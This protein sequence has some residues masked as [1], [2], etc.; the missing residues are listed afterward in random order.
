MMSMPS[1]PAGGV[2]LASHSN[3]SVGLSFQLRSA[4]SWAPA[5]PV[6]RT[7]CALAASRAR[8][9]SSAP[10]SGVTSTPNLVLIAW[11]AACARA[12]VREDRPTC[13]PSRLNM[14]AARIPTG[15][16]PASTTAFLPASGAE[17]ARQA[18][19]AAAVVFDPLLS[20]ITDTRK[21]AKNFLRTASSSASPAAMSLPPMKI[22]VN[23]LSFGARVKIVPSTSPP[24]LRGSTPP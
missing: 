13:A 5:A 9:R 20:S 6:D 3:C 1:I 19:A 8:D 2:A 21:P 23:F 14:K 11:Q 17:C 12:S 22:A 15:P 16:V 18:T 24:T 4:R 7:T 10:S